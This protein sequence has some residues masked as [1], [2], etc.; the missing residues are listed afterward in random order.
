MNIVVATIKRASA[1]LFPVLL[2]FLTVLF[3]V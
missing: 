1:K 2:V 3:G